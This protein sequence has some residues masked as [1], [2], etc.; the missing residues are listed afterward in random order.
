MS[1]IFAVIVVCPWPAVLA[2]PPAV[3][4]ATLTSEDVQVTCAVRSSVV[5]SLKVPVA[6]NC[7]VPP[8]DMLG[9]GGA[10]VMELRVAS[11][12][13]NIAD[14]GNPA[15]CAPM[16]AVPGATPATK[17]LV[18]DAL[19]TVATEAGDEVQLTE[20]VRF[21]VLPSPKV[22]TALNWVAVCSATDAVAGVTVTELRADDSTTSAAV[23]LTEP[24][25]AVMVAVPA[26]WP[27]TWPKLLMLA[28]FDAEELQV[29]TSVTIA[30][31]PSLNVPV[32]T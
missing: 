7:W 32:A 10:T 8:S 21:C 4:V 9:S 11:V 20:L 27:V 25:C 17:P 22:P 23:P 2:S 15:N 1:F 30:V 16:V 6:V 18:G 31:E 5:P 26:D 12:T 19:L 13:V 14:P 28:T 3:M 29:T 24:S